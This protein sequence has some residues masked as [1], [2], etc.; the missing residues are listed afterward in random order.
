MTQALWNELGSTSVDPRRGPAPRFYMGTVHDVE[1]SKA[2]GAP[3]FKDW[4]FVILTIPGDRNTVINRPVW[5]EDEANP[6]PAI[7]DWPQVWAAFKN[8]MGELHTGTPLS[9]W[10]A[11]TRSQAEELAFLKIR[12]VE[13]LA[14]VSDGNAQR[15]AGLL[16][17]RQKARDWLE[18]QRGQAPLAQLRADAEA[19][20]AEIEELRRALKEQAEKLEQLQKTK[21]PEARAAQGG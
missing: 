16:A 13:D 2:A 15:M 8:G 11:V 4:P 21:R 9:E 14:A 10:A 20:G 7:R 12:T 5:P 1:A 6:D 17:L 19:K 3:K 18:A